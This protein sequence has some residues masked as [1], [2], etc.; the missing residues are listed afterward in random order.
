M[1]DA[2]LSAALEH[3]DGGVACFEGD[4][5]LAYANGAMDA[6]V[7]AGAGSNFAAFR[8]AVEALDKT[9]Q[10][11]LPRDTAAILS[12]P[13]NVDIAT[14]D[15]RSLHLKMEGIGEGR[16]VTV[17]TETTE[18]RQNEA[19]ARDYA[20]QLEAIL[21]HVP[22]GVSFLDTEGRLTV[23]N[24]E[25]YDY[26][27]FP[28]HMT[29]GT[30]GID[31]TRLI[32]HR[33]TELRGEALEQAAAERLDRIYRDC[34][35]GLVSTDTEYLDDGRVIEIRRRLTPQDCL[36]ET[37]IDVTDLK[38]ALGE[39]E[40]AVMRY[41]AVVEDQTEMICRFG[42]DLRIT[43]ANGAYRA[44][45]QK[46]GEDIT[47]MIIL[48]LIPE[49]EVREEIRR[50]LMG[51]TPGAPFF[52]DTYRETTASGRVA[53]QTW[54]NRAIF[55]DAGKLI[56]YQSVGR[57]VT[58][59][60]EARDALNQAEKLS[61]MGSLL[62]SV[63]H[64]L[65][66]PLSILVGQAQL[67]EDVAADG[68]IQAR[69]G[70]IRGAA[71][72]CARIV[73]SFL[74]MARQKPPAHEPVVLSQ[75]VSE[76]VELVTYSMASSG[77][78]LESAPSEGSVIVEGDADQIV[79]VVVNILINAQ[80]A[81]SEQ[82][83]DR[84]IQIRIASEDDCGLVEI[85]DNGPGVDEAIKQRIFEPFFTT[86]SEGVGTGIGLAFCRNTIL[87]HGGELECEDGPGGGALFRVR[88]PLSSVAAPGEPGENPDRIWQSLPPLVILFVD[89]EPEIADTAR[90]IVEASGHSLLTAAHGRDALD[91]LA[92]EE[93][94]IV[95]SDLR[96]PIMD[97][98]TL[99]R[100]IRDERVH[101]TGAIGFVTGDTL[102]A[103]VQKFLAEV[104]APLAEKPLARE[105]LRRLI[106]E[107]VSK[108]T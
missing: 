107:I 87:A 68:D 16:L 75:A 74:A 86:K 54:V 59:E 7:S 78:A 71:D 79:Q 8:A 29:P 44:A 21:E 65:N 62:A 93:V 28:A 96:M 98:P 36:V 37:Y 57:D 105:D 63:S 22:H 49:V 33:Q 100:A 55:D 60:R 83:G 26:F 13:I 88:L 84:E 14:A 52:G 9:A 80:Q 20:H 91:I 70:K 106:V 89:D 25:F 40:K 102:S 35:A 64:E 53:W 23:G 30:P 6:L 99:W 18:Q 69:A 12:E 56:E 101:P 19:R 31:F 2:I 5:T 34:R 3:V 50:G 39:A 108:E 4:G 66:N 32:L 73:R 41:R 10:L 95:I 27:D 61:A 67:L 47:G 45:F 11:R 58:A 43:F 103:D 104:D 42:A 97:G 77:V 46:P 24:E 92:R 90:E 85:S 17:I 81:L 15:G 38:S 51:L 94:D 72:R 82:E 76:A 1:T 48:D